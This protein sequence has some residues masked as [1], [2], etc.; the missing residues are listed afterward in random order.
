MRACD[1]AVIRRRSSVRSG[2]NSASPALLMPP[3]ITMRAG[4]SS[5]MHAFKPIAK[6]TTYRRTNPGSCISSC[7]G[8]PWSGS[9][10]IPAHIRSKHPRAPHRHS[11]PSGRIVICP[12]SPAHESAPRK[13]RPHETMPPPMPVESVM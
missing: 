10:Q 6:S 3:P 2:T 8:F 5:M 12:I 9:I 4:F 1:Q 13:F 7:A 11:G